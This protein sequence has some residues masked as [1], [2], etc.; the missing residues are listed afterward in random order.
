MSNDFVYEF[1][2]S[3]YKRT[4]RSLLPKWPSKCTLDIRGTCSALKQ[5]NVIGR[6]VYRNKIDAVGT[7]KLRPRVLAREVT[8]PVSRSSLI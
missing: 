4:R 1:A 3:I 8:H 7:K 5:R 6:E 2:C